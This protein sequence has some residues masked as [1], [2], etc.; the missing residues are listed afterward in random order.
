[1]TLS[2]RRARIAECLGMLRG[3]GAAHARRRPLGGLPL[4]VLT[5]GPEGNTG[6]KRTWPTWLAL[7]EDLAAQADGSVHTTVDDGEHH[8]HLHRP[9]AVEAALLDLLARVAARTQP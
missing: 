2:Q 1:M 9:Q 3:H 5:A 6:R 7:Q 4:T 8:L